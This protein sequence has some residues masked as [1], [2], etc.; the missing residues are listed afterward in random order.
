MSSSKNLSIDP[1]IDNAQIAHYLRQL[2]AH[3]TITTLRKMEGNALLYEGIQ[4]SALALMAAGIYGT[5]SEELS[6]GFSPLLLTAEDEESA[7]YLYGDMTQLLGKERVLFFP[8]AYRRHI[9]FGHT[10]VGAEVLRSELIALLAMG[11]CPVIVTYPAAIAERIPDTDTLDERMRLYTLGQH[12]DRKELRA[13][14]I[15]EGFTLTNYVY[16]PGEVAFRG[17]IVDIFSYNSDHPYRLDF[18]DD[19]IES[20]RTF[21]PSSQLSHGELEQIGIVPNL[22]ASATSQGRSLFSLLPP[23][24]RLLFTNYNG[25]VSYV[26]TLAHTQAMVVEEDADFSTDKMLAQLVTV[27]RI[28]EDIAP[29]RKLFGKKVVGREEMP[30]ITFTTAAQP[31]YHKN[32]DLLIE[33]LESYHERGY[34]VW[35]L[36][37]SKTQ[38]DRLQ[39]I[40]RDLEREELLPR[41]LPITLHEGFEDALSRQVFITDHQLFERYHK[42]HLRS[43]KVR[44][45]KVS[46]TIKDLQN[47]NPGDYI[48]HYDHGIGRFAGL[49]TRVQDGKEEEVLKIDYRNNDYLLV[50]MHNLRKLSKYRAKDDGEPQLSQLG[51]GA[52]ER[53]KEKTKKKI[54][55]IARELIL[56]YAA[57]KESVGFAFSPDSYLQHELEASFI[58]EETPDQLKAVEAVKR[59]MEQTRPMDRLLCGDVGFGKTEVAI[60]AAFKAVCDSKQVAILVPTTILA[61]QHYCSFSERLREL[62][63]RIAYFSRARSAKESRELLKELA[64]GRIDIVIGT[65][66][67]ISKDVVFKDLGLL[68]I[69]EEQRFGVKAKEALRRLQVNVDT[70]SMTAT[71]IPRTLQFSLLGTRDLSN[72]LTPPRNRYP[73]TTEV[74]PFSRE[75]IADAINY[76][77]SR[78]GQVYFVHNRIEDIEDIANLIRNNVPKCRVAVGHGRMKPGELE[79]LVLDFARHEFDVLVATTIIENGIDISNANT[80]IINKA[81]RYGLS[82]LHQ[83]RGRVGRSSRKAFC[84]LIAPPHHLLTEEAKRRLRAIESYSELGSGL[85]IAMQDLDIRGAGNIFGSE[86]S[87]FI[88]E[89]GIDAY[90]KVFDEAVR[91]VKREEFAELY[92]DEC[93]SLEEATDTIFESDLSLVFPPE[94]IP[95]DAERIALYRELDSLETE[96]QI[97]D[98]CDRLQDRFGIIPEESMQ[99]IQVPMLRSLGRTLGLHKVSLRKG[100]MHLF[101]PE[102]IN[103]PYYQSYLFDKLLRYITY[104]TQ[105]C[106]IEEG[107]KGQRVARIHE[108][109]SV[110][111][112]IPILRNIIQQRLEE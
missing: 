15:S 32:F 44:G 36:T 14:L 24:Y 45:G 2:C 47:F 31:L 99:L 101:L 39:E 90:H 61:Y 112:A 67:L 46:L 105:T 7:G 64:E 72:I 25:M 51:S 85:R 28:Q 104:H 38:Y 79:T 59:D 16:E 37:E 35:F 56:L 42:Y 73:I 29:F 6:N 20:L 108:V 95:Q 52:W 92:A 98:Y 78:N 3:P 26:E 65:H 27:Q 34:H 19:E 111:A 48:V 93:S 75:L 107:A 80:I 62:P 11:N 54:K 106:R 74:I 18:F 87:G 4:G 110:E 68:I 33:G 21:D 100:I 69:D 5:T 83:L 91:E 22:G 58:Y 96:K 63:V 23:N 102:D 97:R 84:Y 10:D 94:Y 88:A 66:R 76:E 86:Q 12:V 8:S 17:S 81:H 40:F 1:P 41:L 50:S 43:D 13:W 82:S 53:I 30:T 57:R 60:R 71:P 89:M 103:S 70:L 9:K 49:L 55:S 109:A 77:L